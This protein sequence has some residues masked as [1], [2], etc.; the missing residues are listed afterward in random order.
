MGWT[1]FAARG[2]SLLRESL[3]LNSG[4]V[5]KNGSQTDY[6][7]A[8]SIDHVGCG[9][10]LYRVR[11][12]LTND[13]TGEVL[14]NTNFHRSVSCVKHTFHRFIIFRN[15][16]HTVHGIKLLRMTIILVYDNIVMLSNYIEPC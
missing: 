16:K 9:I 1:A 8:D 12:I 11:H 5:V 7:T 10:G 2:Q 15:V 4:Q 13:E 14:F 6:S 3:V